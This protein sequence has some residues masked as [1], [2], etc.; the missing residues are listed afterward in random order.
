MDAKTFP[1]SDDDRTKDYSQDPSKGIINYWI[2][3]LPMLFTQE[4][5]RAFIKPT[6]NYEFKPEMPNGIK[7]AVNFAGVSALPQLVVK[8]SN[9]ALLGSNA[10]TTTLIAIALYMVGTDWAFEAGD[11]AIIV[12]RRRA[13]QRSYLGDTIEQ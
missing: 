12:D 7:V 2:Q 8:N 6:T 13:F 1:T 5:H 11:M 9:W 3:T 4:L 10:G